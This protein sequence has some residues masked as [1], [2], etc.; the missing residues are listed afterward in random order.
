MCLFHILNLFI[1]LSVTYTDGIILHSCPIY[2][3]RKEKIINIGEALL[4]NNG[5]LEM[6]GYTMT[7]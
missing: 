4:K 1:C 6:E 5:T 3:P 7:F 2:L